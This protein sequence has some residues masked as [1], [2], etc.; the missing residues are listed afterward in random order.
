MNALLGWTR[1]LWVACLFAAC[2]ADIEKHTRPTRFLGTAPHETRWRCAEELRI[3]V[4]KGRL[5]RVQAASEWSLVGELPEG[6][7]L[8]PLD[9]PLQ[10]KTGHAY[11]AYLV[12][13]GELTSARV[14]GVY[15]PVQDAFLEAREPTPI[16]LE[17]I[18]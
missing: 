11:E 1:L 16:P 17:E 15:L 9:A 14:V 3:A 12:V 10:V 8:R 4:A 2:A 6:R 18:P 7:V 5:D 13:A